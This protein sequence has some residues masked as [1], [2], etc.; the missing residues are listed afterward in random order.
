[1]VEL[2]FEMRDLRSEMESAGE[3][4]RE[5]VY[6]GLRDLKFRLSDEPACGDGEWATIT[7]TRAYH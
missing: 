4:L 1:V 7:M 6:G 2:D 5:S 3:T